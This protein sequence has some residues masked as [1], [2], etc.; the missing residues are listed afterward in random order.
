MSLLRRFED[1]SNMSG[2]GYGSRPGSSAGHG[3]PSAPTGET[4]GSNSRYGSLGGSPP[5]SRVAPAGPTGTINAAR[6]NNFFE[7]KRKVQ[8]ALIAELDPKMDLSQTAQVRRTIEEH[9][10]RILSQQGIIL[11][12]QDRTRL[13]EAIAA[14][15]LGFGPIEPL[16]N[17]DSVT[18][19][20]VNGPRMVYVEQH[21]RLYRTDIRFRDDEHVT[22]VIDRII[23]PLGR[24]CDESQPYV[25]ARLPDG[26]RVNAVIPPISLVGPVIT[27]RKFSKTP[28]QPED[29]I[30]LGSITAPV[31]EFLRACVAVRLN[32]IVS[33]GTG[34]GKTTLLNVLSSFIPGDERIIT[35][36]D[37]AELQLRQ[38]HVIPLESRPANIEGKGRISIRDLVANALRM[39]PDRIIVGE[40]RGGEALDMLQAMN[41]GHDGRL[42]ADTR[43]HFT[44]G[45]RRVG[46]Y[47]DE[48]MAAY[49]ERIE[50]R[51]QHGVTVEYITIPRERA[52]QVTCVTVDGRAEATPVVYALR[53]RYRGTMRRVRTASGLE[54]TISPEHP[55]YRLRD[56][57][58]Y[59]PAGDIRPGDWLAAPRHILH[60]APADDE[61]SYWAGL[62]TGD[63]S[64]SGHPGPDGRRAQFV[65]LSIDDAGI[66]GAFSRHLAEPF[67]P[68]AVVPRYGDTGPDASVHQLLCNDAAA[69]ATAVAE[70][71]ALPV[72]GRDRRTRLRW[73][74][75]ARAPR[76]FVAGLFD[77]EG[78]V[79]MAERGTRDALVISSCNREYLAVARECLLTAGIPARLRRIRPSRS[80]EPT[81]QLVVTGRD[82]IL[83]FRERIPIRHAR[84]RADLHAL[85]ERLGGIAANP[86][87]DGIPCATRLARHLDEA[88][89]RGISQRALA[90]RAGCSQALISAYRRG[91]RL[92]TPGR[93]EQLC[94]ALADLG[95]P[96][97]DLLLLARAD[98]RWERVTAVEDVPYDGPVYDL[99]VSEARHSGLLPHNFAA[100]CLL[101]SN[102]MT[103]LHANSPRDALSRL[104]TMV[105]MAGMELPLRAIREQIA[106]AV[107]LIVQQERMRD[108]S[109]RITHVTEVLGMESDVITTQEIFVFEQTGYDN[110][111]VVGRLR[112]T[113]IRPSFAERFEMANIHFPPTMFY[114]GDPSR[115]M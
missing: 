3:S 56:A 57:V 99:Q 60:D 77:A 64:I 48:L 21:G 28:L 86:N 9:F 81:W 85:A 104:E 30:R 90:A 80:A 15:I 82:A 73:S 37:A 40:C 7:L 59:V 33:G 68:Q 18:E 14:E 25:D 38:E 20:M 87:A 92:P 44:D 26:S 97:D 54:H 107:H 98:L 12:R 112:S 43:V 17:D 96:C 83:R 24:R 108:G 10:N 51:D 110:G 63:G 58:E 45:T 36:E 55:L 88:R 79:G 52:A 4:I 42:A 29:L 11:N 16:L 93:L 46:D 100:D 8:N 62:L 94:V 113:G 1:S 41:T 2:E 47:V 35:I 61:A 23:S 74:P 5:E 111:R 115:R 106:S 103:T 50:V 75:A 76:A 95:V 13:F 32:V 71:Y 27:I 53:S 65:S 78:Y 19:I 72:G 84:K 70:R 91:E 105:L 39:R 69:T 6:E 109:R 49:P 67:G 101:T 102:S 31:V 34:S 89:A 22:R 66:A 114:A